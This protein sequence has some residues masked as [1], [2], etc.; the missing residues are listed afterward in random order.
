M[1]E[2]FLSLATESNELVAVFEAK[3]AFKSDKHKDRY[4]LCLYAN[5]NFYGH[6]KGQ[7]YIISDVWLKGGKITVHRKDSANSPGESLHA[8]YRPANE[9]EKL[10]AVMERGS[11]EGDIIQNFQK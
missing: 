11:I 7:A 9:A 8:H 3:P 6:K 10:V 5:E 4:A 1:D 2:N